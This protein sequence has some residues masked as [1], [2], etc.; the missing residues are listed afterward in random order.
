MRLWSGVE[1]EDA[2]EVDRMD[3]DFLFLSFLYRCRQLYYYHN[4]SLRVL[5]VDSFSLLYHLASRIRAF[6]Y[7]NL[8]VVLV[9]RVG[10]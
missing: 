9:A 7:H 2:L 1:S 10:T 3:C 8:L 4:V 6:P 5:R